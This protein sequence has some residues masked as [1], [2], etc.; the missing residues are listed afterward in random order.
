MDALQAELDHMKAEINEKYFWKCIAA[1][2]PADEEE[3]TPE[4]KETEEMAPLWL[5]IIAVPLAIAMWVVLLIAMVSMVAEAWD[6]PAFPDSPDHIHNA[7]RPPQDVLDAG[8]LRIS[9][10]MQE[11]AS[12]EK[13]PQ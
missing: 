4:T 10:E 12:E 5:A 11:W 3:A 1:A 7:A 9:Q 13:D 2:R 6:T 8:R